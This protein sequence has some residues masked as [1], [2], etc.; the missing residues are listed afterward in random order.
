M[1]LEAWTRT[2]RGR[3]RNKQRVEFLLEKA[4]IWLGEEK[5]VEEEEHYCLGRLCNVLF[6]N[7][8]WF[9]RWEI[10]D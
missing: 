5:E 2:I 8:F 1:S 7:C 3:D 9:W 4:L 6:P 10:Q